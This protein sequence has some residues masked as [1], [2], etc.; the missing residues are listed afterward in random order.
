MP[1][2][3]LRRVSL[4]ASLV[5]AALVAACAGSDQGGGAGSS[6]SSASLVTVV[7]TDLAFEPREVRI[8]ADQRVSVR[9]KNKGKVLHDWTI[10]RIPVTGVEMRASDNHAM[11]PGGGMVSGSAGPGELHIAAEV[12]RTAQITFTPKQPGEYVFYCTVAG[13]RQ[14]GMQGRLVV[15]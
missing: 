8:A 10:E 15:G 13:H 12:G 2:V 5:A 6:A 11:E 3:I 14:A 9:L 1:A 7:A 4:V